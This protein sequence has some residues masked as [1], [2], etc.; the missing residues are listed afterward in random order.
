MA[1]EKNQGRERSRRE[2][3]TF[4]ARAR[5]YD[6]AP[7]T[8]RHFY[9]SFTIIIVSHPLFGY[10]VTFFFLFFFLL[11]NTHITHTRARAFVRLT[12]FK[13]V[14]PI[15]RTH[16]SLMASRF[17]VPLR[18]HDVYSRVH[19]PPH[20]LPSVCTGGAPRRNVFVAPTPKR[21]REKRSV[22]PA[23]LVLTFNRSNQYQSKIIK[24]INV[25]RHECVYIV[26]THVFK[27]RF[28]IQRVRLVFVYIYLCEYE[29]CK[30]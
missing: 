3:N 20:V 12:H 26:V 2:S 6:R 30:I 7:G 16:L 13:S 9:Y 19:V 18:P 23:F 29:V 8:T 10:S 28:T 24:S 4:Y 22:T 21:H 25:T 27:S 17:V 14:F 15:S 11:R 1:A 5:N